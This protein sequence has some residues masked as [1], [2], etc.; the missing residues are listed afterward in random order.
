MESTRIAEIRISSAELDD[1]HPYNL[2]N[3][4]EIYVG[5]AMREAGYRSE[6]LPEGAG[7]FFDVMRYYGEWNN[8]GHE[9]CFDIGDEL[10]AWP[11]AS[12]FFGRLGLDDR[13]ALIDDFTQF[14][15]ANDEQL[16]DLYEAEEEEAARAL[17]HPF[18]DRFWEIEKRDGKLADTL[19]Q[20]LRAQPWLV[21]DPTAPPLTAQRLRD[22]IPDHPQAQARKE[23]KAR[24]NLAEHGGAARASLLRL[25]DFLLDR[26]K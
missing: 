10:E 18:D 22:A 12:R 6:E 1:E 9:A 11:R 23:A 7:D 19:Y 17:F 8:G 26:R 5:I 2:C 21:L 14:L 25:R 24:R 15:I 20:W 4:V 3:W 16:T 13:K